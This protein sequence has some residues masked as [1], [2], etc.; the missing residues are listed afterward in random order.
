MVYIESTSEHLQCEAV[1]KRGH[2]CGN[3]PSGRH[4][5]LALCTRHMRESRK[6]FADAEQ[7]W[8]DAG[9]PE[10]DL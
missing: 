7:R 8:K 4:N 9:E 10:S 2:R 1:T 5:G 6:V 3:I